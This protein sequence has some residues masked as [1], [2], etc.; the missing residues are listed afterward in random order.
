MT[1]S[2]IQ[3]HALELFK[4]ADIA[5]SDLSI[6]R[7]A[8]DAST[9][10]YFRLVA[11]GSNSYVLMV[12]DPFENPDQYPFLS[13]QGLLASHS[14]LVPKVVSLWPE[15]GLVMLEDLGDYTLERRFEES[16]DFDLTRPFY[17][18][19]IDQ[20][21]KIH[22]LTALRDQSDCVAFRNAFD[23][24][25]LLWELNYAKK[26]FLQGLCECPDKPK[27]EK[28]LEKTFERVCKLLSAQPR[29][30]VHRD[31]HSR[32]IMI[33]LNQT[34]I[35]D[36]QDARLGTVQYDLVSLLRDSY[37]D[38]KKED[39]VELIGHFANQ[40]EK[41][42]MDCSLNAEF[43]EIYEMQSLQRALKACG[44]FASFY[45]TRGDTRYLKYIPKTIRQVLKSSLLFPELSEF[46]TWL[47]DLGLSEKKYEP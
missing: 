34:Y 11:D 33:K 37:V 17:E 32:N 39:E 31:F 18:K 16:L 24:D 29:V 35:I 7:L 13:V 42:G 2:S 15:K 28:L 20:L 8:G 23:Y 1:D 36:F 38:I 12:W 43:Q 26:F 5:V 3:H 41:Q 9:R 27:T 44:S 45:V 22:G 6:E 10:S 19:A 46:S 14:I 47:V 25:K 21:V 4:R 40:M 30:L